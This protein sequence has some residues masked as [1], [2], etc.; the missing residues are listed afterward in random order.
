M[1]WMPVYVYWTGEIAAYKFLESE[2][3]QSLVSF[4][5]GLDETQQRLNETAG[6]FASLDDLVKPFADEI[7]RPGNQDV[8]RKFFAALEQSSELMERLGQMEEDV[9]SLL[10]DA[11]GLPLGDRIAS[12][13]A[14]LQRLAV[15]GDQLEK[16]SPVIDELQNP[17]KM[18]EK[19]EGMAVR[20]ILVF[21][22][23]LLVSQV[24]AA[25][26]VEKIR[27]KAPSS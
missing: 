4:I 21:F 18:T 7:S 19:I 6:Y 12:I 22:V 17:E 1:D 11:D 20:V 14:S 25:W 26:L 10:N 5:N 9:E 2:T 13:D 24:L 16:L 8:P 3:G 23:C 27:R 15:V